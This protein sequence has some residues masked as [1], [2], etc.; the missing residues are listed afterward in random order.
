MATDQK[1]PFKDSYFIGKSLK[2]LQAQ[3]YVL[4]EPFLPCRTGTRSEEGNYML[5]VKINQIGGY[6]CSVDP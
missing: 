6:F 3:T 5:L 1:Y 4:H 2:W